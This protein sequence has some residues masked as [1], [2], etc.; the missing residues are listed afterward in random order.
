MKESDQEREGGGE[1]GRE[2]EV[3]VLLVVVVLLLLV[4]VLLLQQLLLF[5]DCKLGDAGVVEALQQGATREA[6]TGKLLRGQ[7]TEVPL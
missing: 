6:Q 4:V 3:E 2:E 7:A 5:H 1:G